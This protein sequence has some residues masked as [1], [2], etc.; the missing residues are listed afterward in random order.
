MSESPGK[1]S[2]GVA[3]RLSLA[4]DLTVCSDRA[5]FSAI[6]PDGRYL[7]YAT[8][9]GE[10]QSL[11]LRQVSTGSDI[12]LLP[13]EESDYLGLTFTPDGNYVYFVRSD[14][15]SRGYSSLYRIPSLG[16]TPVKLILEVAK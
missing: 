12:Q 5:R 16:G 10:K 11:W 2:R 13:A 4:C 1:S 3:L 6:S 9:E 14:K 15:L 7:A 8:D